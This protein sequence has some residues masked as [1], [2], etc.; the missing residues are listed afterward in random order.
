MSD[1]YVFGN[2][3]LL[4]HDEVPG[5]TKDQNYDHFIDITSGFNSGFNSDSY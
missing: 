2:T 5:N 4:G 1:D 3:A